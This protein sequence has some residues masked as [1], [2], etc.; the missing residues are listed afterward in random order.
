MSLTKAEARAA[1]QAQRTLT[2]FTSVCLPGSEGVMV[3]LNASAIQCH[4]YSS[5]GRRFVA[6]DQHGIIHCGYVPV[7]PEPERQRHIDFAPDSFASVMGRIYENDYAGP[8]VD[9]HMVHYKGWRDWQRIAVQDGNPLR[10]A[11]MDKEGKVEIWRWER[12]AWKKERV[13]QRSAS[14]ISIDGYSSLEWDERK[15]EVRMTDHAGRLYR[16]TREGKWFPRWVQR[17]IEQPS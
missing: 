11:A 13:R 15:P 9:T 12:N 4:A 5:N 16:L 17:R 6:A 14:R 7:P 1:A 3:A 8:S 2:V 10:F